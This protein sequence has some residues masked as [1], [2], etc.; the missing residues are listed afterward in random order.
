MDTPKPWVCQGDVFARVPRIIPSVRNGE[1]V[2]ELSFE[3]A[4]LITHSCI[5]D[6]P[7]SNGSPAIA[8]FAFAPLGP[9]SSYPALGGSLEG[10]RNR[11][12]PPAQLVLI[13]SHQDEEETV[14]NLH[15]VFYLP[16]EYFSVR[17]RDFEGNVR[18]EDDKPRRLV[19]DDRFERTATMTPEELALLH[20]NMQVHSRCSMDNDL[21]TR[22]GI[23]S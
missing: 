12:I 19:I 16:A 6:K 2:P 7:K 3:A 15:Q 22:F 23:T 17:F 5:L 11:E 18:L 20:I 9:P 13:P 8:Q 10:L 4:L 1:I 21:A 14:A